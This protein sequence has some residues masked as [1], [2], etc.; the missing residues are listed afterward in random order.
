MRP[1]SLLSLSNLFRLRRGAAAR[2]QHEY[3]DEVS[4]NI[5]VICQAEN[6]KLDDILAVHIKTIEF[7]KYIQFYALG[8]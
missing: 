6:N 3:D 8:V 1:V 4:L 7:D 5:N 2:T